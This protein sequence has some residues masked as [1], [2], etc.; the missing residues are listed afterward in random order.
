M[1]DSLSCSSL[2][3]WVAYSQIL[4][5]VVTS[6]ALLVAGIWTYRIFFL[7][8]S[9]FPRANVRH[10]ITETTLSIKK[11][12]IHVEITIDNVSEVLIRGTKA[13][14]YIQQIL[15]LD[16]ELAQ[17]LERDEDPVSKGEY[18]V[19]WFSLGDREWNFKRGEFDVEP[20]EIEV[21]DCDFVIPSETEVVRV[22]S[23][24]TNEKKRKSDIGWSKTT[25]YKLE[26]AETYE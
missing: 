11:R 4:Q 6:I 9:K 24:I 17:L 5:A 2:S 3:N 13:F 20:G 1:V 12:L 7:R 22:Y 21:L 26:R 10:S 15:P 14:I 23:Y 18:E 19:S 8:R 25:D 16:E